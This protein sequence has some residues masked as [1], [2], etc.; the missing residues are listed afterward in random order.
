M[1]EEKLKYKIEQLSDNERKLLVIKI[2]DFIKKE[3]NRSNSDKQKKLVAY[4]EVDN[5]LDTDSLKVHLKNKLPDYM[6]PFSFLEVEKIPL[7]PNGKVDKKELLKIKFNDVKKETNQINIVKPT[8]E[9]EEKLVKIWEEVLDFAPIS[10]KD[11]FF[12]IG[13][14]SL[15]SIQIISKARKAGIE[16]K[17]NQIFENQTILGLSKRLTEAKKQKETWN[18][19]A[20]IR[21]EGSKKPLFCIHSGGGHVFIYGLLKKYL[22]EDRPIYAV[23]PFGLYESKEMHQSVEEMTSEYLKAIRDIQPN[24]PYNILVYCFSASVGNEMAIQ[25]DK[26]EHPELFNNINEKMK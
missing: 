17:A 8:T 26:I 12:E 2:K 21:N 20:K 16:L 6:I 11:N 15:L 5:P 19:M 9:I 1:T 13:G 10:I 25:L 4:L 3:A 22:K 23:Q 14:D 24:G 18:F 7:L